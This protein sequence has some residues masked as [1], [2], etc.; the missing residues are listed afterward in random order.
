MSGVV[1]RGN[2]TAM[3]AI[4][5]SGGTVAHTGALVEE[6]LATIMIP[7]NTIGPNGV[8]RFWYKASN[9]AVNAA[10]NKIFRVKLGGTIV[11]SVTHT[12]NLNLTT[13]VVIAAKNSTVS[14]I[15]GTSFSSGIASSNSASGLPPATID[16][17]QATTLTFTAQPA[18]AGDTM[19]LEWFMLETIF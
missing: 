13:A 1:Y 3:N 18:T 11:H 10:S 19:Q 8:L 9:N 2:S 17:T 4:A 16:T 7:A 15:G 6:T 14:Q 12:A 5:K